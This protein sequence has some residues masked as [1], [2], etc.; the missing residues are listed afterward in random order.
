MTLRL[1]LTRHAKSDWGAGALDDRLRKLNGRGKRSARA[2]GAWLA[3][4]G[5][6]PDLVLCSDAT[7]TRET[8]EHM[9]ESLDH[10]MRVLWT[11]ALY[12]AG[13]SAF[14]NLLRE[15]GDARCV[16]MLGHNP[17]ISRFANAI[18]SNPPRHERFG[19]YPTCATLVARMQVASWKEVTPGSGRTLD[20]TVPR[21]L[22]A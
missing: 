21:E 17:G 15:A 9:A 13:P 6:K 1:I 22:T 14:L 12:L 5:Y 20:F 2:V 19:D 16:L 7:R 11:P 10:P 18:V 3:E 4:Q 8:W